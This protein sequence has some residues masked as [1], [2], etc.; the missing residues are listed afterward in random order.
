MFAPQQ[1]QNVNCTIKCVV[2]NYKMEKLAQKHQ[3]IYIKSRKK[4][5]KIVGN[6]IIKEPINKKHT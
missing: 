2:N 1:V 5:I 6:R 3:H 4:E